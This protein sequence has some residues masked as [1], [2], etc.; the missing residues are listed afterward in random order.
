MK[1]RELSKITGVAE[2]QVRYLISEDF[3]PPPR[4]G[5][6]NADYGDDHVEAISRYTRLRDLGFP[7]PRQ[8]SFSCKPGR[9]RVPL[10]RLHPASPSSL[11]PMSSAMAP[12]QPCS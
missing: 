12:I 8:S 5:R 10:S 11:T 9:V 3:V 7:P 6:A 1:L 4:D 2:R